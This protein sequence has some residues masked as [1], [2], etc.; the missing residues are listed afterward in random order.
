MPA[1]L[2]LAVCLALLAAPAPLRDSPARR[3]RVL[4]LGDHGHHQ[5]AARA[6][7]VLAVLA[8]A[9]I[10][11]TYTDDLGDLDSPT[12][13]RY[14]VLLVYANHTVITAEQERALGAFVAAGKGLVA[15]HC[16]SACFPQ[17]A[18]WVALVG[19]QF[20]RHQDGIVHTEVCAPDHPVMRGLPALECWD[21]TYVH[22]QLS[23]DR[24]VLAERVD[25]ALREPW[26][27]VRDEQ[28]GRVFYT[29]WGHDER[30]WSQPAFQALLERG[31]CWAAGDWALA[32]ADR[33]APFS[34]QP[35]RVPNYVAGRGAE[36][37]ATLKPMQA[38]VS[39]ERSLQSMV[40]P[41]GMHVEL[42]AA[43]PDV[44]KPIAIAWDERGRLWVA[45]TVDY[46][47]DRDGEGS[48]HDRIKICEDRDHD[49]RAD[50]FTVFADRLSIPT[51]LTFA[52]GGVI[53]AQAPSML[54]LADTDGDDRAD[55][56]RE[57]FSGFG[58]LDTHAG[59]S[60]LRYGFDHWIWGSVGYSGFD[61]RV[62]GEELHFRQG[63]FRFKQDGSALEFLTSTTNNTWGLGFSEEGLVFAST[64]NGNPSVHMAIPH[65]YYERVKG[66][67]A[68]ALDTIAE[69]PAFHPITTDVRQ[70]DFHGQFT[71]A[72][73][74]AL[75]TAR[76]FP[77]KYWNRAAF[78]CEPT[79]HL[80]AEL[81]LEPHG[82][83]FLARDGWNLLASDDAWT[84]PVAAEVGPDAAVWVI[85]WYNFIVQHNPT[86]P[87]FDT[88]KGNAYQTPLRDKT[89]G[90]IWRV[91]A[92][93]ARPTAARDLRAASAAELVAMLRDDNLFW[94]STA[95]RLLIER[96]E[97]AAAPA[98]LD[99]LR[100][101]QLDEL[102]L[103][104][105]AMHALWTLSGL[106]LAGDP[107]VLRCL[108]H[109]AAGVRRVA[110]EVL[111][112]GERE[113]DALLATRVLQDDAAQV[114]VAALLA[115]A[116]MPACEAAGRAVFL[117]M[118]E[119]RNRDD[120]WVP[121]AAL[122]AAAR[123]DSGFLQAALE[124]VRGTASQAAPRAENAVAN[125]S[126]ETIVNDGPSAWQRRAY[127][128]Q[129]TLDLAAPGRGG[130]HALRITSADGA[131]TSWCTSVVL[132][133]DT[134]Y[135]LSG[136]IKTDGVQAIGGA[137]GALFNVHELQSPQRVMTPAVRG[138]QDWT[139]VAVTFHSGSLTHL[140]INAL[141]GG[142]GRAQGTAWF[143]DVRVEQLPAGPWPAG[144]GRIVRLVTAQYAARGPRDTIL[145][146]LAALRGAA[147]DVALAVLDGL[148]LGWP[149]GAP[150][151]PFAEDER[152]AARELA[153]ALSIAARARLLGL[154]DRWH[155]RELAEAI[156]PAVA[157]SLAAR[158]ADAAL[159]AA[160]RVTA[161]EDLLAIDPA[162]ARVASV[163]ALIDRDSPAELA[164]GLLDAAAKTASPAVA[165]AVLARFAHLAP[166]LQSFAI[167][168]MLRREP[169]TLDLLDAVEK[170]R[171]P[172]ATIVAAQWLQLAQHPR[173]AVASRARKLRGSSSSEARAAVIAQLGDVASRPG[174]AARGRQV[175]EA[176]CM[177][178]HELM[179]R[180]GKIGP[181]LT[182]V[183]K[184][185]KAEILTD[186]L[187]PNRS[188]EATY[189]LWTAEQDDGQVLIGRLSA[190]T[191]TTVELLEL[192][193]ERHVIARSS[194][195]QLDA[196]NVSTMPEG[197]EALG[198]ED[199]A[200]LLAYLTS[201]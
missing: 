182:G 19:G 166:A 42:F 139:R 185:P 20:A 98:L 23:A 156:R 106:G 143:D 34:Y 36:R 194:L 76:A 149:V 83:S 191:R 169:W 35:A 119:P 181:A 162:E 186:I 14:D 140:T 104:V 82:A 53:V 152:A 67:S 3:V 96:G 144:L 99:L 146:T 16:A 160:A 10:D 184:R 70:V 136:W 54:F 180:G 72:A 174:D 199:L 60:N 38:P 85:D 124:S 65:R 170:D 28:Q 56:R 84:A 77:R 118:Q 167:D 193:G 17:S 190:E 40:V 61:G 68:S 12:L 110:L 102:G 51:S 15:L 141:L 116:E 41:P 55:V 58:T 31:I 39:P 52:N 157:T 93:D 130:G 25:G 5:P 86:P 73:G 179:G 33:R 87:G 62:G 195:R 7:S 95:Q 158:V 128:G 131:D 177:S 27:W 108:E 125:G 196:S 164:H 192:N 178:C 44:V 6:Q 163:V 11:L 173:E 43:E 63:V 101:P 133:R 155:E 57:L 49:G 138:T 176:N 122:A 114:R 74:H 151:E 154:L 50:R 109:Q 200:A 91:V 168:L 161:A 103:D 2:P 150:L 159:A 100:V 81:Y 111:P 127:A 79:G 112:R 135:Q 66:W 1:A 172:R 88:G 22:Q 30:T 89:H 107:L 64:A 126:F 171:V 4:F 117:L 137:E 48:G 13:A 97:R 80:V 9:G 142:W 188:I 189:Q 90:R 78:V 148:L 113:R 47:N 37:E 69:T 175:F 187:D 147:D 183:G 123:H 120:A 153:D 94:R 21:E 115:L 134:D 201:P 165:A 71:A 75:Y 26:T 24:H 105:G 92:D 145:D 198:A 45:E 46:P 129:A 32:L 59:P 197:F 8:R 29:A 132:E 18:R 121:H